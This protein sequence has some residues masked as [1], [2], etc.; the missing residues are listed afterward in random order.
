M[1]S[2]PDCR[3]GR[4]SRAIPTCVN[5]NLRFT[6]LLSA[7]RYSMMPD[8]S[9]VAS[10][11]PRPTKSSNQFFHVPAAATGIAMVRLL[12][13]IGPDELAEANLDC[14]TSLLPDRRLTVSELT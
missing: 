2:L 9:L 1:D 3:G 7:A 8:F 13:S 12:T 14:P 6:V 5:C 10:L 11:L 4:E